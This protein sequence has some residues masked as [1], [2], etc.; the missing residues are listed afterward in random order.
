MAA[1]VKPPANDP[2][3]MPLFRN[4][5]GLNIS[6][7]SMPVAAQITSTTMETIIFVRRGS[8]WTATES[9]SLRRS[10][11]TP[12][13][14][15][16]TGQI[17]PQN[18]R[19]RTSPYTS[20]GGTTASA[21]P[22]VMLALAARTSSR[23]YGSSTFT[24][25]TDEEASDPKNGRSE[26]TTESSSL[27]LTSP[28]RPVPDMI[29]GAQKSASTAI[30]T[31]RRAMPILRLILAPQGNDVVIIGGQIEGIEAAIFFCKMGKNVTVLDEGSENDLG[32][33]IP[34]ELLPKYLCWCQ[35]HGVKTLSNVSLDQ[36]N[37]DGVDLT[38][39][40]GLKRTIPCDSVFV[41]LPRSADPNI[42][43]QFG[44]SVVEAYAIGN[45]NEYGLIREAIRDGNL[46]ARHLQSLPM[47]MHTSA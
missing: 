26:G 3:S 29:T 10:Q 23:A 39:D 6:N 1:M 8:V 41:A 47:A 5:I 2:K 4:A 40:Y 35:T 21:A 45:A 22:A 9:P 11:S 46:L 19:P 34:G 28:N 24:P 15:R 14:T 33:G 17:H 13:S 43:Q 38:L 7:T 30:Y 25:T 31:M 32:K 37:S 44:D 36:I 42:L 18:A 20:R 12:S 16:L 27:P